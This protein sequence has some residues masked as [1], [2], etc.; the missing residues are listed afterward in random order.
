MFPC[1]SQVVLFYCNSSFLLFSRF[2]NFLAN[3]IIVM[4]LNDLSFFCGQFCHF[5]QL[6]RKQ[7]LK[8]K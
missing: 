5:A 8:V 6:E 4:K 2:L 3:E 7:Y 1:C